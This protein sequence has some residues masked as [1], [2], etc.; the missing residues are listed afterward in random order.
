MNGYGKPFP[1]DPAVV[2]ELTRDGM[3]QAPAPLPWREAE[4]EYLQRALGLKGNGLI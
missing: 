4:L 3:L 2:E 1:R